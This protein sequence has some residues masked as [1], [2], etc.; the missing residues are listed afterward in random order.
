MQTYLKYLEK[1]YPFTK[2]EKDLNFLFDNDIGLTKS[3]GIIYLE[4]K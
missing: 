2:Y 3:N 4:R 1:Y